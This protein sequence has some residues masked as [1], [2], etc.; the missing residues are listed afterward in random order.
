MAGIF[1][2]A[3]HGPELVCILFAFG[4]LHH[5]SV[6]FDQRQ[7]AVRNSQ[8]VRAV[9]HESVIYFVYTR[10][11]A[12]D[13]L[14]IRILVVV[15]VV[16]IHGAAVGPATRSVRTMIHKVPVAEI[17][18]NRLVV[19]LGI[20]ELVVQHALLRPRAI[21]ACGHRVVRGGRVARSITEV[22]VAAVLVHPGSLEK[23]PDLN[24]FG[25][26]REFNHVF[27]EFHA[28]ARIPRAPI[29]PDVVPVVENR[30]VDIQRDI[31]LGIVGHERLANGILP[32]ARGVIGH[33]DANREALILLDCCVMYRHVPV[34][35]AVTVFAMPRKGVAA[36]PLE[37]APRK[38]RTVVMVVFHVVGHQH[39]PVIHQ[40][41]LVVI[42][43]SALL[44]VAR[45]NEQ[46][47]VVHE[48]RGVGRVE[49]CSERVRRKHERRK[50]RSAKSSAAKQ[51][52]VQERISHNTSLLQVLVNLHLKYTF[53]LI[54]S[55]HFCLFFTIFKH[56][57]QFINIKSPHLE[58]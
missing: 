41:E 37:G 26:T 44:V 18:K 40:E 32:R 9:F 16:D 39:V 36:R 24:V 35:L 10:G 49:F 47:V 7:G 51:S 57:Q 11:G 25:R 42:P 6:F 5:D 43:L 4:A 48:R 27:L 19:R 14:D 1:R 34:E 20:V 46:A 12:L 53:K 38:Y 30:G 50:K 33:R 17:L 21:Q 8:A 15:Q 28:T 45:K 22:V 52:F 29:H 23:V 58:T 56:F 54:K 3:F 13:F 55:Q 2:A 31:V